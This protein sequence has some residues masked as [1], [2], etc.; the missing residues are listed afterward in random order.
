MP[1]PL[2]ALGALTA[3]GSMVGAAGANNANRRIAN[4]TN[5]TNLRINREYNDLQRELANQKYQ[6]DL[7]QWHRQNEYNSPAQQVE[8]MRAAGLNP[9]LSDISTGIASS[10]PEMS[11][12]NTTPGHAEMGAPIQPVSMD[13]SAISDAYIQQLQAENMK[14]EVKGKN[15]DNKTRALE[16]LYRINKIREDTQHSK[17]AAE[18]Q[19][20]QNDAFGVLHDLDVGLR[21]SE[22]DLRKSQRDLTIMTNSLKARELAH[23]DE[24]MRV[25][26]AN[27]VADTASK[28]ENARL[29]RQQALHL[30]QQDKVLNMQLKQAGLDYQTARRV[31]DYIVDQSKN[32]AAASYWETIPSAE[33]YIDFE[34]YNNR[35]NLGGQLNY[36][37]YGATRSLSPF[38]GF[39][40]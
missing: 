23:F 25:T 4:E 6:K 27:V 33:K 20:L 3:V 35:N 18:Y 16:N 10:S 5:E 32:A 7:E 37:I 21:Q 17:Y 14:E 1:A 9:A 29:S 13:L 8:R 2:I 12:P 24:H 15:I 22:I 31:Q 34:M 36:G 19:K 28:I 40:K 26:I 30:V 39:G 38:K 11:L